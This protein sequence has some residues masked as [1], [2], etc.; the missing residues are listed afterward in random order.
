MPK[1]TLWIGKKEKSPVCMLPRKSHFRF[2]GT[3]TV[4]ERLKKTNSKQREININHLLRVCCFQPLTLDK[5]AFKIKTVT[6]DKE[7]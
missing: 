4:S 6:R 1:C 7:E 2:E 3:K 5:T